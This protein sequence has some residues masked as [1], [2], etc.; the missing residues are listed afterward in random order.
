MNR[1]RI[2]LLM[3]GIVGLVVAV[4]LQAQMMSPEPTAAPVSEEATIAEVQT[5]G[6]VIM[7]SNGGPFQTVVPGQRV[8]T[9]SRLMVSKESAAT[10]VY[11]DGCKQTYS[12]PG[13]Y[14]ISA[15]C[16]LPPPVAV[17]SAGPSKVLIAGAIV[18]GAYAAYEIYDYYKDDDDDDDS[19]P[20]SP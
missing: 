15:E 8:S 16:V 5:D 17:A 13:V 6:G 3:A 9:K 19:S 2:C 18:V 14:E 10:V 7:V 11:D 20:I 1:S 4:P 12:K